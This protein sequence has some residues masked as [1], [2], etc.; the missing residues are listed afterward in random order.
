MH[1]ATGGRACHHSALI[2]AHTPRLAGTFILDTEYVDW[3]LPCQTIF[4]TGIKATGAALYIL[5]G[6]MH[7][8]K[9][10]RRALMASQAAA[11][12]TELVIVS[13]RTQ[14][15]NESFQNM[16][17]VPVLVFDVIMF[18]ASLYEA[19]VFPT[20]LHVFYTPVPLR[21]SVNTS[22]C[23]FSS[24]HLIVLSR[25]TPASS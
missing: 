11:I 22:S 4:V 18:M 15:Q 9:F 17:V 3:V 12:I 24:N 19:L 16:V 14:Q 20:S 2:V 10:A 5:F 13:F 6:Q 1:G 23:L 25:K 7:K 21:V 8:P